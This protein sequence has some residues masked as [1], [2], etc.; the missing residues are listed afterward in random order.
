MHAGA[1][2]VSRIWL[3]VGR[4]HLGR[5]RLGNAFYAIGRARRAAEEF[6]DA[7]VDELALLSDGL[8]AVSLNYAAKAAHDP[9]FL[10]MFRP[11]RAAPCGSRLLRS[12]RQFLDS[13][14]VNKHTDDDKTLILATR[15][16]SHAGEPHAVH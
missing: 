3:S 2:A 7:R 16:P 12:L 4:R 11:L 6:R 8:Q 10:P 14:Q 15:V 5:E 13:A 1:A 9:F